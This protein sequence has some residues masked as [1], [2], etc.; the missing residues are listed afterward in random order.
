MKKDIKR[1]IGRGT[2]IN[3]VLSCLAIS[4]LVTMAVLAPNAIQ[5][6]ELLGLGKRKYHL[7][8]YLKSTIGKLQ[9]RGLIVFEQRGES[10]YIRLTEKGEKALAEY[11]IRNFN[12]D[13]SKIEWDGKWR[14][15]IFDIKEYRR[16]ERDLLR[17]SLVNIGFV[18]VQNSVWVF[19]YDCEEFIFLLKTDFEFGKDVLFMVV[20]K[21]END[22]WLRKSFDLAA[23]V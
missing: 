14:V 7:N 1:P 12:I 17:A 23:D 19:P 4:G 3:A 20:E 15:V 8:N 21:L 6:L 18:K 10:K 22:R 5:A 9:K 16:S 11:Q 2:I 13:K